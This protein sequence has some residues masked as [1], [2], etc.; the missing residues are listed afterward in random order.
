M[1]IFSPDSNPLN[2]LWKMLDVLKIRKFNF[3][4]K[5][6]NLQNTNLTAHKLYKVNFQILLCCRNRIKTKNH[7]IEKV[8][9]YALKRKKQF[10]FVLVMFISVLQFPNYCFRF[11][12]FLR[13]NCFRRCYVSQTEEENIRAE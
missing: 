2:E 9:I 8:L 4:L 6:N 1:K 11:C 3:K 13:F 7:K 12:C 10:L 5:I